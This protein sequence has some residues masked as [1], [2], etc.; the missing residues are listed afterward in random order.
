MTTALYELA[1]IREALDA[2]IAEN[3]GELDAALEAAL[4]AIDGAFEEK[5]ERVALYIR[6]RHALAKAIKEEE[7]RLA[8]RRQALTNGAARLVAYLQVNME[9]VGKTKVNGLLVTVALQ[10]NPMSVVPVTAL[11]EP[12]LRN[13]ASFAPRYVRHEES[14]NLDKKAVLEDHKAG[15]LDPEIAKRVEIR[16]TQSLRIR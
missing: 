8:E 15:T 3:E 6:E 13:I 16:Q 1:G 12:E 4:D 5:V 10:K 2:V 11:D 14:W 7:D 9:R